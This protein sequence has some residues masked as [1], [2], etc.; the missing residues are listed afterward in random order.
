MKESL[1]K[2]S[3]VEKVIVV[4]TSEYEVVRDENGDQLYFKMKESPNCEEDEELFSP[5]YVEKIVVVHVNEYEVVRDQNGVQ[6]CSVGY[7]VQYTKHTGEYRKCPLLRCPEKKDS[8]HFV[9]VG[10]KM[11]HF[12]S[13][14][15]NVDTA[16]WKPKKSNDSHVPVLRPPRKSYKCIIQKRLSKMIYQYHK[17]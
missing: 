2:S 3:N 13:T 5:T 12:H 16:E 7:P 15:F 17:L 10:T 11:N 14:A 8:T 6:C 9:C 4:R 1:F